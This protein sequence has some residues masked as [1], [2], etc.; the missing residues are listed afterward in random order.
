MEDFKNPLPMAGKEYLYQKAGDPDNRKH[1]LHK[2]RQQIF[3]PELTGICIK[4][5]VTE[6]R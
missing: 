6:L 2:N 1:I 5:I 4:Y 3:S